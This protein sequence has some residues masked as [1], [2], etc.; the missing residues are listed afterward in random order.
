MALTADDRLAIMETLAR[1]NQAIDGHLPDAADAWADTFT[2]DGTFRAISGARGSGSSRE[3]VASY[4]SGQTDDASIINLRGRD[5]LRAFAASVHEA[6]RGPHYHWVNNVI[7]EGDGD[8]ASMT[9]YLR[10]MDGKTP[11]SPEQATVTGYY[12]DELRKVAGV[13]KF[14]SRLVKFDS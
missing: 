11:D 1:Y 6:Q 12:R 9:C 14:E 13:W 8:R 3:R 2:E 4:Q 5:A 7:I 10:V